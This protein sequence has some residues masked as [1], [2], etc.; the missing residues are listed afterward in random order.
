MWCYHSLNMDFD[1]KFYLPFMN[2]IRSEGYW[3]PYWLDVHPM[4]TDK[5]SGA[6]P[7]QVHD[8]QHYQLPEWSNEEGFNDPNVFELKE[9]S[10][11]HRLKPGKY[12]PPP[13]M[14]PKILR[15]EP[16]KPTESD[17][18]K[19]DQL[20]QSMSSKRLYTVNDKYSIRRML[21]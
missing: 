5:A 7:K 3:T 1:Q 15:M 2:M 8:P 9:R 13:S 14:P 21:K 19:I 17:L 18:R 11:P 4:N 6:T 16:A 20:K 10:R 12:G